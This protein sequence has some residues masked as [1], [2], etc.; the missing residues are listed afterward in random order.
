[1]VRSQ[2]L[3]HFFSPRSSASA[4]CS[5]TVTGMPALAKHMAMP[6][7]M[8]PAP[9]T[10]ARFTGA[11]CVPSGMPGTRPASRSPK[12]M[13][14]SATLCSPATS[15]WNCSRSTFSPSSK[16]WVRAARTAAAQPFGLSWPRD[17]FSR[18][19][20]RRRRQR[21]RRP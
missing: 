15:F 20:R 8:V 21:G 9:I 5:T 18:Q 13:W 11:G 1:M 17:R 10:T 16:E 6:P 4:D 3:S 7:P 2:L 14:R 19:W 12:K